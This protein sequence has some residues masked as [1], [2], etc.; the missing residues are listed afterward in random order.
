MQ[1]ETSQSPVADLREYIGILRYRK[2]TIAVVIALVMGSA[3]AFSFRQTPIYVS[4]TRVLVQSP[5]TDVG[6]TSLPVNLET[7]R[8]LV[9]SAAVATIVRDNLNLTGSPDVLLGSLDV[10][11]E[12][13]TEILSIRY[14]D[15]SAL[16]AQRL[17]SGFA[18]AYLQFRRQQALSEIASATSGI[19]HEINATNRQIAD[20]ESRIA[21]TS[22]PGQQNTLSAQ[23]DSFIARLGVLQQRLQDLRSTSAVL[24]GGGEVVQPADLPSAPSSPNPIRNGGLALMVGLALGVGVAFLREHLDDGLRGRQDL[25]EHIGA[26]VLAT[27]PHVEG[28]KKRERTALATLDAP[29]SASAEAY[30][31]LRTNVQFI[32]STGDFRVLSITSPTAGEGKTATT[33]N[34]AVALAQAGKR[35]VAV[36]CDLRKP[37]LHRFFGLENDTGLTSILSGETPLTEAVQRPG[38]DNLRI[39][40]SG[41]IPP[42]PSELLESEQLEALLAELAQ[43]ADFVVVDTPPILAVS[44]ALSL[45]RRSDGVLVVVDAESSTRGAVA[46]LREQLEQVGSRIVG[47]VFNN[48][49]P[50]TAR[51]YPYSYRYYYSYQYRDAKADSGQGLAGNGQTRSS[52]PIDMW[53]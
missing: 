39:I 36:S 37:R 3:L 43:A 14:S 31:T 25:E 13:N 11:V 51:Y 45:A 47:G 1:Q 16:R 42:N 29:K 33:A 49:D 12:T 21:A 24:Q 38:V 18:D 23:R 50:S 9:N 40:A 6:L 15:P 28:W 20:L 10:S 53:R 35:V 27:V 26:P 52:K 2:W 48:F 34:L 7:E 30:R 4:E 22:D 19:Q 8:A 44:D 46:H 41:P 32:A 17:A 5:A